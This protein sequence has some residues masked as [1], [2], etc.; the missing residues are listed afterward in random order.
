[1]ALT[2]SLQTI[3]P[4]DNAESAEEE[5]VRHLSRQGVFI[6]TCPC[7]LTAELA[8]HPDRA[9]EALESFEIESGKPLVRVAF[10]SIAAG[11]ENPELSLRE[12][13]KA[14][15]GDGES[16]AD[17]FVD[18]ETLQA[19]FEKVCSSLDSVELLLTAHDVLADE[20]L[21]RGST[22]GFR[23]G[24][25]TA[26]LSTSELGVRSQIRNAIK[27]AGR[28]GLCES[29][30]YH[31][32]LAKRRALPDLS[33]LFLLARMLD[34]IKCPDNRVL[35]GELVRNPPE[36]FGHLVANAFWPPGS[37]LQEHPE[38]AMRHREM[39]RSFWGYLALPS[40]N[41][42]GIG[43]TAASVNRAILAEYELTPPQAVEL[44]MRFAP[45]SDLASSCLLSAGLGFTAALEQELSIQ[46]RLPD[47]DEFEVEESDTDSHLAWAIANSD[48]LTCF[49]GGYAAVSADHAIVVGGKTAF[50]AYQAALAAGIESPLV[51]RV[52]DRKSTSE[53]PSDS[54]RIV[55][56]LS[57]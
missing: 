46:N 44:L 21:R 11:R 28:L 43:L 49:A 41:G 27:L 15:P 24:V 42:E 57:R 36:F 18:E 4:L 51:I 1:M 52:P 8:V 2:L 48:K 34:A 30:T 5:V 25:K 40:E 20:A 7:L 53:P 3:P 56:K 12:L 13:A 35:L 6:A 10:N 45:T 16:L 26:R 22:S 37:P 14:F 54:E 32:A 47:A 33:Q 19:P 50:D 23:F 29:E 38:S 17:V 31:Q 39:T 55:V 9:I